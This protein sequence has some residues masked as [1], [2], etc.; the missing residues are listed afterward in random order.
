MLQSIVGAPSY[1]IAI[2]PIEGG[3]RHHR[4]TQHEPYLVPQAHN[5]VVGAVS[6]GKATRVVDFGRAT[7]REVRAGAIVEAGVKTIVD[8][9]HHSLVS[10]ISSMRL[11]HRHAG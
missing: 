1:V 11:R 6:W 4:C 3:G 10:T 5:T 2:N 8:L 7:D 9:H